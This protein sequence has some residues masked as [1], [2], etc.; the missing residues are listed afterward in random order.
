MLVGNNKSSKTIEVKEELMEESLRAIMIRM[1]RL[2]WQKPSL[3]NLQKIKTEAEEGRKK[4]RQ[5]SV[6]SLSP[7][8]LITRPSGNQKLSLKVHQT[9]QKNPHRWAQWQHLKTQ[10]YCA[11]ALWR[12]Q[13]LR[14]TRPKLTSSKVQATRP[15]RKAPE[16]S[17]KLHGHQVMRPLTVD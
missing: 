14:M 11:R 5:E 10:Q 3:N 9:L 8:R 2:H 6:L 4:K 12:H 16:S 13:L 1:V 7:H 17:L 15:K